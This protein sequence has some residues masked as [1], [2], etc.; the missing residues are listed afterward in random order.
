MVRLGTVGQGRDC[1][2]SS[3]TANKVCAKARVRVGKQNG[4]RK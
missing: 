3:G 1:M 4:G 2:D